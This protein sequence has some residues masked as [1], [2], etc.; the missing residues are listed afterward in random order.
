[1]FSVRKLV[2]RIATPRRD[3]REHEQ[4][5][6][7]EQS[8]IG[9][10]IALADIF[11]RMGD[12]ELDRSPAA[13]LEID[14]PN[15]VVRA[16]HVAGMRF[17]VEQLLASAAVGDRLSSAPERSDEKL[18]VCAGKIRG[19]VSGLHKVLSLLHSIGEVRRPYIELAHVGMQTLKR[20]RVVG[21]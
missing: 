9:V 5:T 21:W 17:A 11:G 13:R 2:V 4:P 3:H 10:A 6:L 15:P 20:I 14:E 19:E 18:P 16:E 1:M 8:L 7:A 12:V